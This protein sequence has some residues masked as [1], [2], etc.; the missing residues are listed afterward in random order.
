MDAE[1]RHY[2]SAIKKEEPAA[3]SA[4]PRWTETEALAQR[5]IRESRAE[6]A[7]KL[8]DREPSRRKRWDL[9]LL[10]GL[11]HEALG[12]RSQALDSFEG[13]ADKLV[14][15]RDRDG[16]QK[17][18][19]RFRRPEPA[20]ASVR[21]LHFLARETSDDSER[22]RLLREAIAIRPGDPELHAHLSGALE[23]L[24]D[25]EGAR[26][27]R[28]RSIELMLDLARP[29][30]VSEE[31]LRSVEEDLEHSPARV[32]KA[33]LRY[34]SLVSWEDSEPLLDLALPELSRRA[35]GL[36]SW[37]DIAPMAQRTPATPAARRL[38]AGLL[39]VA[40]AREPEPEAII[41]GSGMEKPSQ[42]IE[43]V[44]TRL[45]NILAFPPG[46]HVAHTSW[47]LGR[48]RES[49]G[50]QLVLDFPG[51]AGHRMSFTMAS[52]SLER[53][54]SDGLRVLAIEDPAK[55]RSLAEGLDPE[56]LVRALRDLGGTATAAQLKARVDRT[57]PGFD[58]GAY[59]KQGKDR[60]REEKRLDLREAYR[61]IYRLAED[62]LEATAAALPPLKPKAAAEGLGLVRRFLKEHPEEEAQLRESASHLVRR[63]AG[64]G[65]LD[66][67]TR[68]QALCY[69]LS[70]E[71]LDPHGAQE[72]LE[73]L[74][75]EGLRP[76]DLTLS[77]N[78]DQLL[79]LAAGSIPEEEF[80]WR[81]AE[82]RLP[83]L[84]D[85]ARKR[86]EGLLGTRYPRAAEAKI[87][88]PAEATGL[89]ARLIEHFASHPDDPASP[90]LGTL[91]VAA[92]RLLER[93]LG[94]GVP[95]RL[96]SLLE[97]GGSLFR[98]L[99]EAP[100]DEETRGLIE[101]LVLHW[102]GSERRLV[103]VLESLRA[104]GLESIADEFELRRKARA[105]SLLEG[106]SVDDLD[107]RFTVMSRAT[108]E[109]LTAELKRLALEL[110]TTI[111]A[112]ID[113]ARQLGDLRE[114]AEYEAAK[115]KQANTATRVQELM[116]TLDRA[117]VL[118][119]L[120]IDASRVGVGTETVLE[121]LEAS[122]PP[123]TFWVLGEGD[124][125]L[126]PSVLSYRAPLARPLL[127]KPVGA[128]VELPL[129]HGARRY[130]VQS[131]EK[132]LPE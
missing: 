50:E 91:V 62:G 38:L 117:R 41:E 16:V 42:P 81:A 13:V 73:E 29:D 104:V 61:Q 79:D 123:L 114:N 59:L 74:I 21:F 20:N 126:G 99:A 64:D 32:G 45:P 105:Q 131:I 118:E 127:G 40:M 19:E 9:L 98:R 90:P 122:D 22:A 23:R 84:R 17:L 7:L 11:L 72:T 109:R 96:L 63:W 86:L 33:L 12:Q 37:Y 106:R 53:L 116:N 44:A 70:W 47:G 24:G 88:R 8:I 95:E 78:Q 6:A 71:A 100:P 1:F 26:E 120:E 52:R 113:K 77:A 56:L 112:A 65:S 35:S 76:D 28:L 115:L 4:G 57:L 15:T 93:D 124:A 107:T 46:A 67:S 129:P 102:S 92:L 110:R 48:V 27:H 34:A 10:A 66:P 80:L 31:L 14:A 132:R 54:P 94:E 89:A 39:R 51:R 30:S 119:S 121:P 60:L 3:S 36:L 18:L 58:L 83:R 108:C 69:A 128:E 43:L 49:D 87:S 75:R 125:T 85:R 101:N 82:S 111:P 97:E 130:R 5:L 68:A 103:P 55:L 2:L 25:P